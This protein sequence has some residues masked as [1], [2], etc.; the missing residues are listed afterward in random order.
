M[1]SWGWTLR[2]GVWD[3]L[4]PASQPLQL[5]HQFSRVHIPFGS[6]SG[7]PRRLRER[8]SS[9]RRWSRQEFVGFPTHDLNHLVNGISIFFGFQRQ[10]WY[11]C[12]R[13]WLYEMAVSSSCGHRE[14]EEIRRFAIGSLPIHLWSSPSRDMA[15]A[16]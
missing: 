4:S 8:T 1:W 9:A 11:P 16:I 13:L 7:Q 14:G 15:L 2:V 10:R 12:R 5:T 3:P 6:V